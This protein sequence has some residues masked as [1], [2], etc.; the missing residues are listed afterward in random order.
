MKGTDV[1][2]NNHSEVQYVLRYTVDR[3]E[4]FSR[5]TSGRWCHRADFEGQVVVL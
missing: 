4:G 3:A 5:N 2:T 1:Q